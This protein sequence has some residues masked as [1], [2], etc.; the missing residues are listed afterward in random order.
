MHRVLL[1]WRGVKIHSYFALL[2]LALVCAMVVGVYV[3]RSAG[4]DD[5]RVLVAM[6]ALTV[7]GLIGARLL[8]VVMN[9][10]LYRREPARIWRRTEGGA[11]WQGALLLAAPVSVP[12]LYL[13]H[14]PFARFWD[15]ATFS[16]LI[17]LVV[18]KLGCLLN[19]CCGGRPSQSRFALNLP[20]HHGIRRHR[21]PTQLLDAGAAALVLIGAAAL[22]RHSPFPGAVFLVSLTAYACARLA[23]QTMRELQDR[24]GPVNVQRALA[25]GFAL[26]ALS[27]LLLNWLGTGRHM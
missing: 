11:A 17:A 18:G 14:I 3:A 26:L 4:L 23:T 27:G 13:L 19:G 25:A 9:W 12:L 1:D 7:V 8:F 15:V 5:A 2:Y 22:W 6:L 20:D 21:I 16:V 24:M 10:P